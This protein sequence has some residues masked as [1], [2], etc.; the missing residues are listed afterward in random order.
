MTIKEFKMQYA[1]GSLSYTMKIELA[2]NSNTPIEILTILS[3]DI[4]WYIKVM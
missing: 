2:Y 4:D 3:T 1:L